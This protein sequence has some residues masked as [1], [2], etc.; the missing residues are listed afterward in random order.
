MEPSKNSPPAHTH[1]GATRLLTDPS[2]MRRIPARRKDSR[3]S[4]GWLE[5]LEERTLLSVQFTPGPYVVPTNLVDVAQPAISFNTIPFEP[6]ISVNP[7]DPGNLAVS[8]QT[9][10]Q[11]SNDAGGSYTPPGSTTFPESLNDGRGDTV[12][13]FDTH[14]ATVLVESVHPNRWIIAK[15]G[16][17]ANQPS[18]GGGDRD[19]SRR[20]HSTRRWLRTTRTSSRPEP[21]PTISTTP[22]R[23]S[24]GRGRQLN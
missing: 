21:T 18:H 19:G 1:H 4:R 20:E 11:V 7:K 23:G 14:G 24:H 12:T 13:A 22:G 5:R 3:R 17:R 15:R 2:R 16:R 6:F 10:L 9:Q 8:Q